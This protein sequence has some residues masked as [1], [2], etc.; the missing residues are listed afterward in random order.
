MQTQP[1][2]AAIAML[3]HKL[4]QMCLVPCALSLCLVIAAQNGSDNEWEG[5]LT[6]RIVVLTIITV[7]LSL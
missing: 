3:R 6:Q 1:F 5:L 2:Q 4:N 7:L